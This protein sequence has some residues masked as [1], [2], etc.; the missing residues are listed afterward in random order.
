MP[1][2]SRCGHENPEGFRYCGYCTAPLPGA[3]GQHE[4]RK[5]ITILFADV[6][7]STSLGE[8]LDPESVRRVM[9][10]YF[11]EMRGVLERHGGT[12]E[13][14]IGD[15]VMAVF[16]IP[17]LHEDDALRAVRSAA[18]MRDALGA[19]NAEL[20]REHGLTIA[21]R[22]GVDT[23]EVVAGSTSTAQAMVTGDAVNVAARLEQTAAPGQILLGEPTYRLVRHAVRA[24]PVEPLSL[25]GKEAAVPAYSLVEVMPE[26]RSFPQRLHS[27][28]VG[29]NGELALLQVAFARTVEARI[30][31]LATVLGP[32]GV[33]K[34]RMVEEFVRSIGAEP[35]VLRGRCLPYGESITFWP[36]GQVVKQAAKITEG[37]TATASMAKL[38]ALVGGQESATLIAQWVAQIIGLLADDAALE[39]TFWAIRRFVETLAK[40]QPLVVVF[41]DMHWAEPTFLDL[42]ESVADLARDSPVLMLCVARQELL[43]LRPGWGGG[44]PNATS[45]LLEPLTQAQCEQLVQ[46]LMGRTELPAEARR[47]IG[48]AAEGN[49]LFVEEMLGMLIDDGVLSRDD[50][51]WEPSGDLSNLNP[52]PSIQAL[53]AARLDQLGTGERSVIERASVVGRVFYRG[54]VEALMPDG[55]RAEVPAGLAMLARRDLIRPRA[56]DLTGEET[57][58]FR[59]M[60]IRD[61]AYEAMPKQIRAE[62]HERFAAW[63]EAAAGERAWEYQEILGYHLEQA[64]RY[65]VELGP[66]DEP[67]IVLAARSGE[68]LAAAGRRAHARGDVAGATGLLERAASLLPAGEPPTIEALIELGEVLHEFGRWAHAREVLEECVRAAS[69][70]GAELEAHARIILAW[71]LLTTDPEGSAGRAQTEARRVIPIFEGSNDHRGLARAWRALAETHAMEFRWE[72]VRDAAERSIEHARAAGDAREMWPPLSRLGSALYFGPSPVPQAIDRIEQFLQEAPNQKMAEAM[73]INKLAALEAMRGRFPEAREL[74]ARWRSLV[75]EFG[76]KDIE[77]AVGFWSGDIELLAGDVRAAEREYRSSLEALKAIGNR[78]AT[79]SMAALLADTLCRQ[80]RLQEAERFTR[81]AEDGAAS[82]DLGAQYYWR[83]VRAKVL[84]RRGSLKEAERLAREA[85]DRGERTDSLND[86]AFVSLCLF[87]VLNLANRAPEAER[88]VREAIGFYERKGNVPATSEAKALLSEL[89]PDA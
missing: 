77:A 50:E 59:H 36:L 73:L 13:K 58:A 74:L 66:V 48:E 5:T 45:I 26:A 87:E 55:L 44:K 71:V 37:D 8:R 14:F 38:A 79:P 42:V 24:E 88:V 89:S 9:R 29:R 51:H 35:T 49:P 67:A 60:L 63:L 69:G 2:C 19:L 68:Y 10:M 76:L 84:A 28:M 43:D 3:S 33:G 85:V 82:D 1:V 15:A 64:Y 80:A 6:T 32:A 78:N 61:A 75:R 83:G 25:K 22:I 17:I 7:G 46:N 41:E 57:Y 39:E 72:A 27:P 86:R 4:V 56:S 23:G 53:L 52:P 30:C 40:R 65:R 70:R 47:R 12:V 18:D 31:H 16:G 54:A 20:Q 11:D 62:M 34:S 81:E 21:M